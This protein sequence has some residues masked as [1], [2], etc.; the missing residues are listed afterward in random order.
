MNVVIYARVSSAEQV[1]GYSIDA[2]VD[3]CRDWSHA[4]GYTVSQVYIEPGQSA[5]TDE[6]PV[7]QRMI[8]AVC[9]GQ[10]E[11]I[12]V[13]KVDRF[14]RNL[15]DLLRYKKL[16]SDY[17][18]T[19]YSVSEE[20]F[21][22]DS[23]E[24]ELVMMIMGATAEYVAKNI[25]AEAEKGQTAKAQSGT[26]P[27]SQVP[28]GY[29]R[30][31]EKRAARIEICPHMG[32]MIRQA[33]IDFSG[34]AY[35]ISEWVVIAR[36]RGYRSRTGR[37]VNRSSWHYI[38]R[39]IFYRGR[40]IWKGTEYQGDH[41]QLVDEETWQRVQDLLE[42][43]NSGGKH[44][45]HFWLL[46]GLLWSEDHQRPMTGNQA[47]NNAYYRAKGRPGLNPVEHIIRAEAAHGQVEALLKTIRATSPVP[48]PDEWLLALLASPHLGCIY[49]HLPNDSARRDF[50]RLV[51]LKHGLHVS[52]AGRV[53]VVHLRPGFELL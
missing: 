3:Q 27:G 16:L 18:A 44:N 33:F 35:T 9:N 23:P 5:K 20:F 24:N 15:L 43:R 4:R 51:F 38:F 52:Q 48:A 2:Q 14:A 12:I 29:I 39:N 26:W 21:N 1:S 32:P 6:R 34:G 53:R 41:P 40:F 50:L 19:I 7:F 28:V 25:G 8:R 31:G 36:E 10:I 22:G 45:R 47:K 17:D 49:P 46:R 30:V 13:H 11:A 37:L 42:S